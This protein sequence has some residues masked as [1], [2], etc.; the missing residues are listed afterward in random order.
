MSSIWRLVAAI[1]LVAT[2]ACA[3]PVTVQTRSGAVK[4]VGADGVAS[5]KGIPFAQAPVGDLRWR[6]P[7][8]AAA[9]TG[10]RAADAFGPACI[11]M[12][13][14]A[15]VS[16][17]SEDCLTLNVFTPATAVTQRSSA[18]LP[19]M[20]WIYGGGFIAGSSE[21]YVGTPFA[22]RGVVLVTLNY[23]LGRL[24]FF[25]HPALTKEGEG[26]DFGFLDQIAALK[27]VQANIASFGGDPANVT[28][29]GESAG[30]IS[31]N[32]LMTS[33]LARG[34]FVKAISESGFGRTP[35]K[36][37]AEAQSVGAA[38]AK[39]QGV[40][41]DSPDAAKALRALPLR[42][43]I[44]PVADLRAAD[45]PGPI[46]D[47]VVATKT[48]PATF[49]AGEQARVPYLVG[50]N[51]YEI[52]LFPSMTDHPDTVLDHLGAMKG[53]AVA[54]WGGGD[55][56]KAVANMMTQ[57]MIIEPNRFL[58]RQQ[59][60]AGVPTYVYYF[61]YVAEGLRSQLPGADHGAEVAYVFGFLPKM[62]FDRP[63]EDTW[64][65]PRHIPA[66]TPGDWAIS[67]A[68]QAYW[69]AFAKTGSPGNA[70]GPAW[71][72]AGADGDPV[73]EFGD[74]GVALRAGFKTMQLDLLAK[75][76]D[77]NGG[78]LKGF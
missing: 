19:V 16:S 74:D 59:A 75:Q 26:A 55:K 51:S 52:S 38:F 77:A 44:K 50:G 48:V 17:Q 31:V 32:Y 78:E 18:K 3:D 10:V 21:R 28:I 1:C 60:K 70:G 53:P 14:F 36:P 57:A 71:T 35:G 49:I 15:R 22:K 33:P 27:W 41:G 58:A 12:A 23:R 62:A 67:D 66:A 5:F 47:G 69:V 40:D 34:L 68:L 4:G 64:P 37:L 43:L 42:A 65:G 45:A 24:G 61:S 72:V 9:W 25:A 2:T 8:P 46:I 13:D 63:P 76:A 54:L 39:A 6:A 30:A 7:R 11:Q 56:T 73:M 29:F 20:V